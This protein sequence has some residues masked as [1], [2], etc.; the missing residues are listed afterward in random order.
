MVDP[1]TGVHLQLLSTLEMLP[2]RSSDL[3]GDENHWVSRYEF[4]QRLPKIRREW[5]LNADFISDEARLC[6]VETYSV[7]V[8]N[9]VP[10]VT[11]YLVGRRTSKLKPCI[12]H[13][14]GGGFIIGRAKDYLPVMQA[15]ALALDCLVASV[16]YRLAPET[17]F[18]GQL[19][20][21]YA[22]LGWLN[23]NAAELGVDPK[24]IGVQGESAGGGLA[25]M[26]SIAARDRGEYPICFQSLIYPM[27]DNRTEVG[28]S[29]LSAIGKYRWGVKANRL[30]WQCLLGWIAPEASPPYGSVPGRVDTLSELPD[31]FI[32]VG[33]I[34][35]FVSEGLDFA[36]RLVEQ[37][38]SVAV[39]S[40][41]GVFHAFDGAAPTAPVTLKFRE[42]M[43]T[44][45]ATAFGH[46]FDTN[47][48]RL[49]YR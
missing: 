32:W 38:V 37:G 43:L 31:T 41:P 9:D 39:T 40:V 15:Q 3:P 26:L 34:D 45:W 8:S 49:F 2:D 35:L 6:P 12:L 10:E 48:L 20:D 7:F 25:A 28:G 42:E 1:E 22:V 46:N 36:R 27:L 33:G 29:N 24:L 30:G 11:V 13:F 47:K 16:E 5:L 14:H 44:A 17:H 18:P 23:Q 21:G 19:D 4:E